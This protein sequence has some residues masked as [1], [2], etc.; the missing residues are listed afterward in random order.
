MFSP[1]T[2]PLERP[3]RLRWVSI[4]FHVGSLVVVPLIALLNVVLAGYETVT[5]HRPDFDAEEDV[6]WAPRGL[7]SGLR[8][9]T[10]S[11]PCQPTELPLNVPLRTN[12]S[13]QLF[14]YAF[15]NFKSNSTDLRPSTSYSANA[16]SKCR[17]ESMKLSLEEA[18][19]RSFKAECIIQCPDLPEAP[20]FR[21]T[22]RRTTNSPFKEDT[23]KE[24]L[25]YQLKSSTLGNRTLPLHSGPASATSPLNILGALDAFGADMLQSLWGRYLYL[26]SQNASADQLLAPVM[27]TI[28]WEPREGCDTND[29]RCDLDITDVGRMISSQT[30]AGNAMMP[31][32][33]RYYDALNV[34]IVNVFIAVRD[35]IHFELRH[36]AT[37][38]I[39]T[40][41]KHF[42]SR[43]HND[44][45][46]VGVRRKLESTGRKLNTC[47]WSWG[48]IQS[49]DSWAGALV[50]ASGPVN[51]LT[52]PV[53]L[54]PQEQLPSI[55]VTDYL[56]PV[57]QLKSTGDLIVSV[58]SGTFT[59]CA[60]MYEIFFWF[61]AEL[62]DKYEE[63]EKHPK[64]VES[65]PLT[66][67]H[68]DS[69][70]PWQLR[71]SRG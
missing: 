54:L 55:F 42:N 13:L 22:F 23:V 28:E 18:T 56:C 50:A 52:I 45:E 71:K 30:Y 17:V 53:Q 69:G 19:Y 49:P 59:M 7:P 41:K 8:F 1:L 46:S 14:T 51:N 2:R 4:T 64:D 34:T 48:C 5:V 27:T 6:W 33:G 66:T 60:I 32:P 57:F 70:E 58:F 20:A 10:R 3:Y 35:A 24:Y 11:G 62:D 40:S 39:F 16:L 29:A 63:R 47:T 25:D 9:H 36:T 15:S 31:R 44:E 26:A 38:N 61:T 65:I 21:I 12:S 37:A 68:R 43:I 67:Q